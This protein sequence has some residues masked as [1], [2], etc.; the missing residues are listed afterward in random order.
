[1]N[2]IAGLNF[3]ISELKKTLVV[4]EFAQ[5]IAGNQTFFHRFWPIFQIISPIFLGYLVFGN[6]LEQST[7]EVPFRIWVS[8]GAIIWL[9][10]LCVLY[11]GSKVFTNKTR[12]SRYLLY[13]PTFWTQISSTFVQYFLVV[14]LLNGYVFYY[15]FNDQGFS[16]GFVKLLV[17]FILLFLIIPIMQT[18]TVLIG[19]G[20]A[21]FKDFKILIP[22]LAQALLFVSP[23]FFQTPLADSIPEKILFW[24]NPLNPLLNIFRSIVLSESNLMNW[25]I[26]LIFMISIIC[27]FFNT[28]FL[29]GFTIIILSNLSNRNLNL[30]DNED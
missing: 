7:G 25:K 16:I 24:I 1:M 21:F 12:R 4:F 8:T 22:F 15:I 27:Y 6:L 30:T 5:K 29:S 11:S 9:L 13:G 20:C 2:I 3:V 28:R 19:I 14:T 26:S 17:V 18:F 23:V 10:F